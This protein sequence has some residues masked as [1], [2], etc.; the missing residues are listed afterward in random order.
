MRQALVGWVNQQS[1]QIFRTLRYE[2]IFEH[3][4]KL[5][6]EA[7]MRMR[8]LGLPDP[9]VRDTEDTDSDPDASIFKQK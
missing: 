5:A 6:L 8:F 7:V 9:L 3:F 2:C 4:L 1:E